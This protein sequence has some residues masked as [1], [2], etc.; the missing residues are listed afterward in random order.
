MGDMCQVLLC[1]AEDLVPDLKIEKKKKMNVRG[2]IVES[3]PE[4]V[5]LLMTTITNIPVKQNSLKTYYIVESQTMAVLLLMTTIAIILFNRLNNLK[6][7]CIVSCIKIPR[8]LLLIAAI[9]I[10]PVHCIHSLNTYLYLS[11][12][13]G[14]EGSKQAYE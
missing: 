3:Q 8:L 2:Y 4:G 7:Y 11:H 10:I 12:E 5:L 14:S 9:T 13:G 6:T 1:A